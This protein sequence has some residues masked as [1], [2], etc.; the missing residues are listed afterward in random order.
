MATLTIRNLPD[1][2]HL[3]LKE[4]AKRNRRSLNQEVIAE[5]ISMSSGEGVEKP[6]DRVAREIEEIEKLRGRAT[7]FLSADEIAAAKNS[8][9]D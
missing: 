8:G 7:S 1:E 5:L 4:R 2:L 3:V 6:G 9:R